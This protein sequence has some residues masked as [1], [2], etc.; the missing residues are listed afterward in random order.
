M[1]KNATTASIAYKTK[2]KE[3]T[4]SLFFILTS[5]ALKSNLKNFS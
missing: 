3:G 5:I 4:K 2:E 1:N